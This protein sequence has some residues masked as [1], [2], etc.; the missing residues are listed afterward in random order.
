MGKIKRIWWQIT[1]AV[2]L[3]FPFIGKLHVAWLTVPALNC[4]ACPL[5]QGACPLGSLQN[6][7][8]IGIIPLFVLGTLILFGVMAGSFYCS[9]ICPFGFLQDLLKRLS[10]R[11][12]RMPRFLGYGKYAFLVITVLILPPL[13]NEPF[14]CTLCPAG[15]LE[16]GIP[17]F[18]SAWRDSRSPQV[19]LLGSIPLVMFGWWFWI[20][21]GLLGLLMWV[22]VYI[23]RPFCRAVCPL[24]AIFGLF[25]RFTIF[26]NHPGAP[27]GERPR[28]FLKTCPVHIIDPKDVD[29]HFCIKCRECY[30]QP[31]KKS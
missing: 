8:Q 25:N 26:V 18:I 11:K 20:K 4:Y 17:E 3:N 29:S 30:C 10:I 24:G 16:G 27:E 14:F 19:E 23:K 9:H 7:L 28:Y 31:H 2:L 22:S 5:A 15:S 12:I 21:I 6:F 1:G 13:L